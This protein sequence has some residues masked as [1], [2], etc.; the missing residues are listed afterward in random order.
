MGFVASKLQESMDEVGWCVVPFPVWL[1]SAPG[2]ALDDI[3]LV[4]HRTG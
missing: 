3:R 2:V 1:A 4:Q